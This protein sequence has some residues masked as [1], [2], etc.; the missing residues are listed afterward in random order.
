MG[1]GADRAGFGEGPGWNLVQ[2][3]AFRAAGLSLGAGKGR[4]VGW[5]GS[6]G[7]A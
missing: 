5:A 1:E 6:W 3:E 4:R 7:V 2:A